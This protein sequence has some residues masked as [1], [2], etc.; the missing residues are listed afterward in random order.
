MVA[1]RTFELAVAELT[2][3]FELDPTV[4]L[5]QYELGMIH[6][7][8]GN[9]TRAVFYLEQA[10]TNFKPGSSAQRRAEFEITTLAWPVLDASGVSAEPDGPRRERFA[11][12]E[13][14]IWWGQVSRRFAGVV[15]GFRVRWLDPAGRVAHEDAVQ[16][17]SRGKLQA[18]LD[19]SSARPGRWTVEVQAGD[20]RIDQRRFEIVPG[21]DG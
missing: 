14:V 1:A 2:L 11:P 16:M 20:S 15:L 18:E 13:R 17:T 7:R 12:G 10:A 9:R 19:T 4:P 21:G 3:A 6:K 8:L 5:V